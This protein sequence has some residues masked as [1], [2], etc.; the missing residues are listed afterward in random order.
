MKL[1]IIYYILSKLQRFG[2][3]MKIK[4]PSDGEGFLCIMTNKLLFNVFSVFSFKFI[5]T[6]KPEI[7]RGIANGEPK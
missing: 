7:E 4:K 5:N 3:G 1:E 2:L 6:K